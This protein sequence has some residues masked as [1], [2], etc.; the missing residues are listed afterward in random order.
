[1]ALMA[2][3]GRANKLNHVGAHE[4]DQGVVE[5]TM[6]SFDITSVILAPDFPDITAAT[7]HVHDQHIIAA[8]IAMQGRPN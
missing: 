1:M 2:I 5:A 7:I 4:L 8:Q 6:K 3:M